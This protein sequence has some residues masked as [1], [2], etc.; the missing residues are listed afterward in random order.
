MQSVDCVKIF[1]KKFHGM[2][3]NLEEADLDKILGGQCHWDE[4]SL[5]FF[6]FHAVFKNIFYTTEPNTDPV[7]DKDGAFFAFLDN[8]YNFMGF[9]KSLWP[10]TGLK[11]KKKIYI[12]I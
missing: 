1:S 9:A 5:H 11:N 6:T 12:S 4:F 8:S 3:R 7:E 10:K 2:Y